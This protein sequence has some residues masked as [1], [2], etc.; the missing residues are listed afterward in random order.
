MCVSIGGAEMVIRDRRKGPS[1]SHASGV[2]GA[3]YGSCIKQ[4][5]DDKEREERSFRIRSHSNIGADDKPCI[6]KGEADYESC[7]RSV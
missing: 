5:R 1:T 6:R 4:N 2:D 7:I 3:D